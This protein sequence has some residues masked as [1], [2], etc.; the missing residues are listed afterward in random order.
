MGRILA[1]MFVPR[2]IATGAFGANQFAYMPERGARDALAHLVLAWIAAFGRKCKVAVYCSDVSGAFD[3]VKAERLLRKLRAR[4]IDEQIL[5]VLASWLSVRDAF[6]TVGG[7]QS[8][9]MKIQDMVFQGTVLGPPLW[10]IFYADAASAIRIFEFMEIIFADDLNAFKCFKSRTPNDAIRLDMR[11]CQSELHK[12]GRA[13]QVTFDASKESMHVLA[14]EGGE[15]SNFKL[16]GVVFDHALSMKDAIHELVADA[17]WKIASILRTT[18]F[19]TDGELVNLYKS[20]LLSFSDHRTAAIYHAC[21][22]TL[23]P[24]NRFQER[25]LSELGISPEDALF[26]FHLAP[27]ACRRDMAML[28][29][30]HRCALGRGPA[31]FKDFFQLAS[32]EAPRT[33]FGSRQHNRQLVDIRNR[34]FLEIERRNALGLIWVY[35]H[36]PGHIVDESSVKCFQSKLQSLLRERVLSGCDD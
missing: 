18:R 17:S 35:N 2:M 29:V 4:G 25:F 28:G 33:R 31:H 22:T 19:F 20:K 27:L 26:H 3:K 14:R 12:W 6:V 8:R 32:L 21:D 34:A 24:L 1:S 13:N 5:R 16:L 7:Q 10:N 9:P 15:G 11:Q 30:L 23:A 36:L